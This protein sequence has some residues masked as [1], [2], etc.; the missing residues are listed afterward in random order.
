MEPEANDFNNQIVLNVIPLANALTFYLFSKNPL[1]LVIELYNYVVSISGWNLHSS[2]PGWWNG[3][4]IIWKIVPLWVLQRSCSFS[5]IVE[6]VCSKLP[7][8]LFFWL[9]LCFWLSVLS[10][11]T[12]E[13]D[14]QSDLQCFI[15]LKY[16]YDMNNKFWRTK[17]IAVLIIFVPALTASE[18]ARDTILPKTIIIFHKS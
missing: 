6:A 4:N 12:V 5:V 3:I 2:V 11:W 17:T 7:Q 15:W 8:L 10:I 9:P 14:Y 18:P 13:N 1:C 16:F